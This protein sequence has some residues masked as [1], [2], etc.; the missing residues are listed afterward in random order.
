MAKKRGISQV[1]K[2]FQ[3]TSLA[4]PAILAVFVFSYVPLAGLVLAFKNFNL[5]LGIIGSPWVGMKNFMFFFKNDAFAVTRN[6]L[7]YN[8]VFIIVGTIFSLLFA[9][10]LNEITSRFFVKLYQTIFFFPYFF[11]WVVVAYMVY[12][13]FAA[14]GILN[15]L[16][17]PWLL[18]HFNVIISEFYLTPP[19]WPPFMVFLAVWKGLGYTCVLYYAAIMGI[20]G[21]YYEAA[22]IDGASKLQCSWHIT[23]PLLLPTVSIMTLLQ[24]GNIFRADFGLFYFI[25]RQI[26]KLQDVT[27][28]IDVHVYRMLRLSN[29]IGMS[30]AI[31]FYQ[32]VLCFILVML[33]NWAAKKI[34]PEYAIF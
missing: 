30:A 9:M 23:L 14:N 17:G 1:R 11:S 27:N 29:D 33:S 34:D 26:G 19:L 12:A 8:I 22:T 6:T 13:F 25:P 31:G 4:F 15:S 7:A 20:P 32:S 24:I 18:E 16:I 5:R 2:N 21:D 28:V 10:M 3:L